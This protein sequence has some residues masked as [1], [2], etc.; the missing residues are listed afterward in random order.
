MAD[1]FLGFCTSDK[2]NNSGIELKS[3]LILAFYTQFSEENTALTVET[4][5]LRILGKLCKSEDLLFIPEMFDRRTNDSNAIKEIRDFM[6]NSKHGLTYN[7]ERKEISNVIRDR[8]IYNKGI[9]VEDG[10]PLKDMMHIAIADD[11]GYEAIKVDIKDMFTQFE[12][13]KLNELDSSYT[14][15]RLDRDNYNKLF[16]Q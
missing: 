5:N 2:S 15:Y 9:I 4:V 10:L 1:L 14:I 8:L 7:P 16:E 11:S 13:V 6:V 3:G 12:R